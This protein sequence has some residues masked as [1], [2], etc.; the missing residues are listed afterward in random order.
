MTRTS[1]TRRGACATLRASRRPTDELQFYEQYKPRGLVKAK[2]MMS[3]ETRASSFILTRTAS[4]ADHG[5]CWQGVAAMKAYPAKDFGSSASDRRQPLG[6]RRCSG[7][8]S[9]TSR[10]CSTSRCPRVYLEDNKSGD[11]QLANAIENELCPSFAGAHT[12]PGQERARGRVP[13][14]VASPSCA[15]STTCACC[16]RRTPS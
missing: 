15:P 1:T 12:Y 10:R 11:I 8:C 4:S 3:P 16:C 6:I 5:A 2:N 13:E 7:S 9:T 14:R